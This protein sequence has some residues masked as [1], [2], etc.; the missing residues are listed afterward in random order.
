VRVLVLGS[1]AREHALFWKCLQSP[2]VDMIYA[3]PGNGG[4][5]VLK[6]NV[7]ITPT[8][9][10]AVVRAVEELEID[11][12]V[13]G[14]DDAVAAG[15]ADALEAAGKTVFGPTAAAGRVESSKA[16]AKE[17]MAA[18]GVPTAPFE[19]FEDAGAARDYARARG[20]GLVVKADGLALGKGVVVCDTVEDTVTA[21]DR[22]M[23]ER[24][25]GAA[26]NRVI[27]EDRMSGRELSLMCFSDGEVA[28]AMVPAR[29]YKRVGEG[30]TGPNTGGMGAYSPPSDATP[31][32]VEEILRTC[33]QP[34]IDELRRRGTPYRGCLY[35]QVMLTAQ[36]P[37]VVEYNARFG[38]PEAQVVLP[39][40][41][42]DIVDLF[43]ACTRVGLSHWDPQWDADAAVG[44][45]L[46]SE[47]YPGSY[48][49]NRRIQGLSRLDPGVIPFHAGTWYAEGDFYT[50]GGRV[51]TIV[52][53]GRDVAEAR[54]RVYDN[55][56][57]VSFDGSFYRPDI[58]AMEEVAAVA[59]E[60]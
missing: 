8:D 12:T 15:V 55:I 24:A 54:R 3:A 5:G 6:A 21:I 43:M 32:L 40:L 22:A 16:F 30:D 25:F 31:E 56:Q 38:D 26:G 57:R 49:K 9:P 4:T 18:A 10:K 45:V 58:A 35:V 44:V 27:L 52:A 28:K 59:Q 37:R 34:L 33:A 14:P 50:G 42:T 13:I 20:T 1:G 60:D 11:L 48:A 39:R 19:L 23:V 36:G 46:A 47:G 29:D 17:L 51:L 2:Q 7:D 53:R 41:K